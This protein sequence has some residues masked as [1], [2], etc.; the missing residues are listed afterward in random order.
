[1]RWPRAGLSLRT[2]IT[3]AFVAIVIGGT[4]VS[5]LIGSRI[6]TNTLLEQ[7]HVRVRRGIESA[8]VIYNDHLRQTQHAVELV[9]NAENVAAALAGGEASR[10]D[11]ELRLIRTRT[12]LGFL[13]FVDSQGRSF[14]G[15][16]PADAESDTLQALA[17][18][19]LVGAPIVGTELVDRE[20]L[21]RLNPA[22]RDVATVPIV[23]SPL[24]ASDL[25]TELDAGLVLVAAIPVL[26]HG[27]VVG[28]V[29]GG[30]LL[31]H[32]YEIVDQV[33]TLVFGGERYRGVDIGTATIF[34]T[35]V[36]VSTNVMTRNGE[37]A[38]GTRASAEV[39]ASVL[40][41]N[42]PY[43]HRAFVVS[44][45]YVAA[46]SPILDS[47]DRPVGMLYVGLPEAPFLAVRTDVMSTFLIVC[48]VGVLIV[49]GLTYLITRTMVRP[50]EEMVKATERI[51]GG[52]LSQGVEV[53]TSDEI[54]HLGA[55]FN[56]MLMS[57]QVM[58]GELQ[59]WARTLEQKVEERTNELAGVQARMAQSEKLA[60]I[61]R[62]SAGVA[63]E[64]NNPLGG[65]LSL[66]ML[67]LEDLDDKHP[68]RQ[69]LEI[70]VKQT[71]R[72][73]EI[74]KGLLEFSRQSDARPTRTDMNVV[75]ETSLALL[76]RQP[77]FHNIR[78]VRRLAPHLLPVLLD[79]GQAQQVVMNVVLNAVDAMQESGTLTV[80]TAMDEAVSEVQ[81]RITD[82]GKGI[83][84]DVLPFIF[85]P[86]FTTKKVGEGTGLGLAIVHGV[87]TR[88]GGRI[89]VASLPTGTT[90]TVRLPVL[91]DEDEGT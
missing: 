49:L 86:F 78:V 25:R 80:E 3:A 65:I 23:E 67:Q 87:V 35:D 32:T 77:I 42:Q 88:A 79:P 66:A 7:A 36:R 45:W 46:Y 62:L 6:I 90:F 14:G 64:I 37:R 84:A 40:E 82:T 16:A 15:A 13:G 8:R 24:A 9:A 38:I 50:L 18:R 71:L 26:S 54:G 53:A 73:R 63:H 20:V 52:D 81:L 48:A 83:P 22:L 75:L 51:A 33:K 89:D 1:M 74:V 72:C 61:G 29:Y 12:T 55:S 68:M 31:N 76:E 57:L 11:E 47:G 17:R 59:E 70:I 30:S 39:R 41:R 85:E 58:R 21:A 91:G 69:D 4:A 5:T 28:A 43:Y 27:Q 60:S 44:E 19:A 34:A 56:K 10:I 2:R